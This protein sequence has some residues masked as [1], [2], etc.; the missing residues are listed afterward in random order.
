Q[1][2]VALNLNHPIAICVHK[3]GPREKRGLQ[4]RLRLRG[5]GFVEPFD[6]R[7]KRNNFQTFRILRSIALP[8]EAKIWVEKCINALEQN[9]AHHLVQWWIVIFGKQLLCTCLRHHSR[10]CLFVFSIASI[11][12]LNFHGF[13]RKTVISLDRGADLSLVINLL[14]IP[15]R[16][17]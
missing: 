8:E 7:Y 15:L 17:P 5:R 3:P 1:K 12:S 13:T 11:L 6:N 4:I 16:S 10:L 9:A 2:T 14:N